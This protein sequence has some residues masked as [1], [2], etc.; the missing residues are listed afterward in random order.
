MLKNTTLV[1][2]GIV[3]AFA[4]GLQTVQLSA[5]DKKEGPGGAAAERAAPKVPAAPRA[6]AIVQRATP[7]TRQAAPAAREQRV[8]QI[9]EQRRVNRVPIDVE[10]REV[11]GR[12]RRGDDGDRRG[13]RFNFG[14]LAFYFYDG[15]YHGDCGYLRRKARE[16]GSYYWQRRYRLCREGY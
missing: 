10:R 7:Q 14:G 9:V 6:P 1:A 4:L 15:Y 16:T 5:Q 13:E 8:P 2:S 12:N 3:L 11:R